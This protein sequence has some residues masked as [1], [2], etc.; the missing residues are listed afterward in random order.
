MS[1]S[2]CV[3]MDLFDDADS[4]HSSVQCGVCNLCIL[5]Q[6]VF[7]VEERL[8]FAVQW[9]LDLSLSEFQLET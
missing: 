8:A 7:I 1:D 3:V 9:A 4:P 6:S 5:P 2:D